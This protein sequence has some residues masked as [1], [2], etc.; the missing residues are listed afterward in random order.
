MYSKGSFPNYNP[1]RL[2]AIGWCQAGLLRHSI[3][4]APEARMTSVTKIT[5]NKS[6]NYA[7]SHDISNAK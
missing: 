5:F 4:H 2:D 3:P 7:T 6:Y 1:V